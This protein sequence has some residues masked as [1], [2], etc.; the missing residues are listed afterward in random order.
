MRKRVKRLVRGL[1]TALEN[2]TAT[3]IPHAELGEL[4]VFGQ[5]HVGTQGFFKNLLGQ[6][7]TVPLCRFPHYEFLV[8]H[9]DHVTDNSMYG[10]YLDASW[11]YLYPDNNTSNRRLERMNEFVRLYR[12]IESRKHLGPRAIRVPARVCRRPDGKLILIHGNHRASA[13]LKT[14]VDLRVVFVD[15]S[16]HLRK[17]ASVPAEF[18]GSARLD[19]PYQSLFHKET[20]LLRG[21]RPDVLQRIKSVR[22]DDLQGKTVL[23][24]G[25]NIGSN[26]FL[27]T[28]FGATHATGVDYSPRL[29]SAAARLNSFMAAPAFFCVYDLNVELADEQRADTVFCFSVVNHLKNTDGIVQTILKKTGSVLY[30]E[31]HAGTSRQD[32]D[33]L[34]RD[35]YFRTVELVG[36]MR[37]GIHTHKTTRPLWRCEIRP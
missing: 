8:K 35:E 25:C 26:C 5:Q 13:A 28:Q 2:R 32:Y 22:P 4:L 17:V 34:L 21:R 24:L 7:H 12:D 23:E 33:Y 10:R 20:E 3:T 29:I 18:Y 36:F 9:A 37:D 1:R 16:E 14:G 19:M 15:R 30:F 27:A 6:A 31:G 11:N